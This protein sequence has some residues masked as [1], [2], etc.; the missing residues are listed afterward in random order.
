MAG[1]ATIGEVVGCHAS[2]MARLD[3]KPES[4]KGFE[5]VKVRQRLPTD[6]IL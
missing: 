3:V 2:H 5:A 4:A 6:D 1:R